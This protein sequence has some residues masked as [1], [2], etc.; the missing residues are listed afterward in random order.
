L[1]KF[2]SLIEEE[3]EELSL[4]EKILELEEEP[5]SAVNRVLILL[6]ILDAAFQFGSHP[7][8]SSVGTHPMLGGTIKYP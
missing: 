2:A 8:Y 3:E 5:E 6:T 7:T 4:L 1:W